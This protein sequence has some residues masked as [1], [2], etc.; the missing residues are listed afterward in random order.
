MQRRLPRCS[1][2]LKGPALHE[3]F[4]AL[5]GFGY[6]LRMRGRADLS[7]ITEIAVTARSGTAQVAQVV[8][9]GKPGTWLTSR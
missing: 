5:K 8:A 3:I 4:V 1:V 7:T 2:R 9:T 6:L